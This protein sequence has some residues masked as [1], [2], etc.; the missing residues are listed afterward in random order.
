MY[1]RIAEEFF[2]PKFLL[3]LHTHQLSKADKMVLLI[4]NT[5]KG[6]ICISMRNFSNLRKSIFL[7]FLC[8]SPFF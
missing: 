1:M 5:K 8:D 6:A 7:F 4:Y 2:T 3:K